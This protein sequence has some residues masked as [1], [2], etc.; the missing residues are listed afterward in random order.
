[1]SYLPLLKLFKL[2]YV[3][4]VCAY[5]RTTHCVA[6]MAYFRIFKFSYDIK[7]QQEQAYMETRNLAG[8]LDI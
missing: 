5:V 1:V 7:Y 6:Y 3:A 2:V 4:S 8:V